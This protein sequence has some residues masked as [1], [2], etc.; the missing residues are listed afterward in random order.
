MPEWSDRASEKLAMLHAC[1]QVEE[2]AA[3]KPFTLQHGPPGELSTSQQA[4]LKKQAWGQ[5][6]LRLVM[7]NVIDGAQLNNYACVCCSL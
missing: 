1:L 6:I 5:Y 7:C 4:S 3:G 2:A